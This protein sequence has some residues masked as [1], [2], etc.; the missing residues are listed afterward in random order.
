MIWY[1]YPGHCRRTHGGRPGSKAAND[2]WSFDWPRS[3]HCTYRRTE[4]AFLLRRKKGLLSIWWS[5]CL[6]IASMAKTR[7]PVSFFSQSQKLEGKARVGN[8]HR[9]NIFHL[10]AFSCCCTRGLYIMNKIW[11]SNR[12]KKSFFCKLCIYNGRQESKTHHWVRLRQQPKR[13]LEDG[14]CSYE[15]NLPI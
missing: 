1:G 3:P 10:R 15:D 12:Q 5:A 9:P 14:V 8:L 11:V 4:D 2:F 13:N 7:W 6:H